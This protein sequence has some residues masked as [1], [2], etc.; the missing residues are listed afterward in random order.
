MAKEYLRVSKDIE[1]LIQSAIESTGLNQSFKTRLRNDPKQKTLYTIK[2]EPD[3]IDDTEFGATIIINEEILMMMYDNSDE[4]LVVMAIDEMLAGL[5]YDHKKSKV[6]VDKPDLTT[7]KKMLEL[8]KSEDVVDYQEALTEVSDEIDRLIKEGDMKLKKEVMVPFDDVME[9]FRK[10]HQRQDP[11]NLYGLGDGKDD[12]RVVSNRG[13]KTLYEVKA[14]N[15]D[16]FGSVL[17]PKTIVINETYLDML[18]KRENG[19][20]LVKMATSD[21]FSSIVFNIEKDKLVI[22]KPEINTFKGMLNKYDGSD[23]IRFHELLLLTTEQYFE[24]LKEM[25]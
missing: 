12:V 5:R 2:V 13:I 24:R 6:V 23:I 21:A 25:T 10:E 9:G 3:Y 4:A 22:I 17:E 19:S 11:T 8:Y 7:H 15:K 20:N 14:E 18:S 1:E 16:I